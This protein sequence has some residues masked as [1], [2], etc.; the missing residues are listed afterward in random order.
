MEN[1]KTITLVIPFLL[2]KK[3]LLLQQELI[4]M[5]VVEVTPDMSAYMNI[6][7]HHGIK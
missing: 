7:T 6:P 1:R 2:I 3:E 5:M 4:M